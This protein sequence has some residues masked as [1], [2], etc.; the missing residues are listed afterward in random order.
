LGAGAFKPVA[1]KSVKVS[2]VS[3]S[4]ILAGVNQG[5]L[6]ASGV[7]KVLI[8]KQPVLQK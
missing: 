2:A 7:A 1:E 8:L 6:S 4:A 5:L 3:A